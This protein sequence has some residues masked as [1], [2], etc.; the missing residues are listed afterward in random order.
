MNNL[1]SKRTIKDFHEMQGWEL[2]YKIEHAIEVISSFVYEVPDAVIS[3]SGGKDS[4]V[5]MH[6]IRNVMKWQ[7]PA[8]FVNTG[9]EYPEV[10]RFATKKFGNTS[11]LHPK[12][13]LQ[14][15]IEKYGFP[16]ISKEYSKMIYELRHNAP[17]AQRYITGVQQDGTKTPFIL[18]KKY[19]FLIRAQFS[20]SDKCC[21]FLK[22]KPTK[23]LNCITGEM[24][25]E[26]M[27]REKSWLRTGCNSFGKYS[28]SKPFSIWTERD[29][30]E[31]KRLFNIELCELY[32]DPR[33]ARTGCMFCG[34][35]ATFENISRFEIVKERYPKIY[36]HFLKIENGGVSYQKALNRC[37]II[38]PD[39]YGYQRT[40]F[41]GFSQSNSHQ[42]KTT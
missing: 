5:L 8:I 27:L 31:Y 42:I 17:H 37:G 19:H 22:K 4:T 30:W 28:K 39:Q 16:L 18:P 36:S 33:V 25:S 23:K 11:T 2:Q 32:D 9:N 21:Y 14:K 3:F 24:G 40:I 29:I 41:S 20:C 7:L 12:T 1:Q 6:L 38:L 10:I 13:H 35:G 26:S 34:F 15:P